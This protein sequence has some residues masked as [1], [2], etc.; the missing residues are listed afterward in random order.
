MLPSQNC[1][2]LHFK[3]K[4]KAIE[5]AFGVMFTQDLMEAISWL[6]SSWDRQKDGRRRKSEV[7]KE[8]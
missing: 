6:K 3:F 2:A 5:V 4:N 1:Q 7:R 8:C